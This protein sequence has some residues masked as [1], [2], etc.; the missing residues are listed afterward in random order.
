[1]GTTQEKC[2]SLQPIDYYDCDKLGLPPDRPLLQREYKAI[3]IVRRLLPEAKAA[4]I[5]DVGCGDGAFLQELDKALHRPY[6]YHG[7]DYSEYKVK[8]A[9]VLPYE[10]R[11]CNLEEGIPYDDATFDLVYSGEVIEHIYNPDFMLEECHRILKPGG[12]LII[13]TPNLQAWY[14]RMLF[15]VGIQPLF[16]EVSTKSSMIGAGPM[17]HIRLQSVPV[18]HLRVFNR[19]GLHDLMKNEGFEIISTKGAKFQSLPKPVQAVDN[20]FNVRP[21]L[22]SNLVVTARKTA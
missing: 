22:A 12:L 7:V 11:R 15:L 19:R 13:S 3:D 18:G 21:S 14:N 10:F 2:V 6:K 16:Y 5:L 17:R 9:Q 1:M 4:E 20:L 8:K